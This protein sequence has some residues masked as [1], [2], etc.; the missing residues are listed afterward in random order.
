MPVQVI[1]GAVAIGLSI[2]VLWLAISAKET[3]PS[4]L[5]SD[6][7]EAL[8]DLRQLALRES[9]GDRV[10][11]PLL[12]SFAKKLKR[13]TPGGWIKALER[14]AVLAG[15]ASS[16]PPERI[17]TAKISL[18]LIGVLG[19]TYGIGYETMTSGMSSIAL[20][21]IGYFLPDLVLKSKAEER[22]KKIQDD[23]PDHLDQITMSV[24]AGLGFEGALARVAQTGE[25]PMAEE[26]TRVI[27]EMQIGV[28]RKEALRNLASRTNVQDLRVFV[29]AMIQS[30]QYGLPI[31]NVL[32]VQASELRERR[33]QRAEERAMKM[34]VKIVFPL[35]LC[36]FPSLFIVLLGPAA[37]RIYRALFSSG[38][39][40]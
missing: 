23:L 15:V 26:I 4:L 33:R 30:E 21:A 37:I 20:V 17:V 5:R 22:Q 1:L 7:S 9:A 28:T 32:R 6:G 31:A 19:G 40:G 14:K 13:T 25:G 36:I 27:Q 38:F 39:G 12:E 18:A 29:S 2:P 3:R 11:R 24:D 35:V 16:W 8:A 10:L 34:P